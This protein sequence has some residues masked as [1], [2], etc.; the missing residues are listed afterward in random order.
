MLVGQSAPLSFVDGNGNPVLVAGVAS[1]EVT[2]PNVG[3]VR[4]GRFYA[5]AQ[6]SA[7]IMA[8]AKDG[9][10]I[11]LTGALVTGPV[12]GLVLGPPV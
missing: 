1:F 12:L 8:L 4:G 10:I 5:L 2:P 9:T 7:S 6:G 11:A 3:E